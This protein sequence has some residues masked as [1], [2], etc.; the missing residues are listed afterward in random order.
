MTGSSV[1][2]SVRW[3]TSL[4]G[5]ASAGCVSFVGNGGAESEVLAAF[6]SDLSIDLEDLADW[7]DRVGIVELAGHGLIAIEPD[8]G[9]QGT[10]PEVLVDLA[11]LSDIGRSAGVHWNVN[12]AVFLA[13]ADGKKY[14]F[15]DLS[16]WD[17]G[18]VAQLPGPLRRWAKTH[19]DDLMTD[20]VSAG[21][22]MA[23][24]FTGVTP[25]PTVTG[26]APP[27][28]VAVV[29]RAPT[30]IADTLESTPLNDRDP[31]MA[32][33]IDRLSPER[34][35]QIS[36]WVSRRLLE[37]AHLDDDP[38]LREVVTQ[39]ENSR[40]R[41]QLTPR[42]RTGLGAIKARVDVEQRRCDLRGVGVSHLLRKLWIQHWAGYCLQYACH[43]DSAT[44]AWRAIYASI[45][46]LANAE[47]TDPSSP[48]PA[49]FRAD[50]RLQLDRSD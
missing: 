38:E 19:A 41:P 21:I 37:V 17:A 48:L 12:D 45:F 8:G 16:G 44:A 32:L 42:A 20:P 39:F 34:Q 33:E 24:M 3:L 2:D 40:R 22:A 49:Q 5:L 15:V 47:M 14:G 50:L 9:Y 43:P 13:Y 1:P 46:A 29:P 7:T 26:A 35:R 31:D 30:V 28:Y 10:R 36:A 25:L 4:P 18:D 27:S 6:G 11:R 23:S